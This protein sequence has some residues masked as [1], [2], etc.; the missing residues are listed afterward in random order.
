MKKIISVLAVLAAFAVLLAV[1]AVTVYADDTVDEVRSLVGGI[2][3]FKIKE[4]GASDIQSWIDTGL[5]EKAGTGGEWY[6]MVLR[7][8]NYDFTVFEKSLLDYIGGNKISSATS[9]QKIALT[10]TALG[11]GSSFISETADS[12]IGAQ[13]NMSLIYGLHILNNGVESST[14]TVEETAEKLLSAQL[15]DGGWAVIGSRGDIDVT[16]MAI[17]A[18][19][20][21][22]ESDLKVREAVERGLSLISEKQ[23]ES[24][25]FSGIDG[26]N[27]ESTA[28]VFAALCSLGIDFS[29][30][31]R[32]IKNG[33]TLLDAMKQ[34]VLADGS[35]SHHPDGEYNELATTQAYYCLNSYLKMQDGVCGI[36]NF[37]KKAVTEKV[38]EK[39][40][41]AE[42]AETTAVTA[43]PPAAEN[44]KTDVPEKQDYKPTALIIT[45]AAA[46]LICAVLFFVGKRS[47]K[48]Y[49][50]VLLIAGFAA[51]VIVF[52]NFSSADDYY[53]IDRK[54]DAVGKVTFSISCKTIVGEDNKYIPDDGMIIA[55]EEFEIS[56][57]DTV[58]DVLVEAVKKHRIQFD[59]DSS[60]YV[61][62]INYLYEFDYGELSGWMYHVNGAA[63]SVYCAGY[64]LS[65][66]D[67]VEW[68][69]TRNIGLDL[70]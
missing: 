56:E 40:E 10:L 46:I 24:G 69:Y 3:D 41:E 27:L 9:R 64:K 52:T 11:S 67:V 33:N 35:F 63:P 15:E 42:P 37:S 1:G 62:G 32:F 18:L 60:Y 44:V 43:A 54:K 58:Y 49:I 20:P 12:T 65:D 19:A 55:P 48:N 59:A 4:C 22:C 17:Q 26:Q 16:A 68:L 30:D 13:G 36:Y 25:D 47:F 8:G 31:S 61:S 2:A 57:G 34:Y 21:L 14:A 38:P 51:L 28:Q 5:S 70:E 23:L 45:G 66:G 6:I 7:D 53:K 29:S 50:F 39:T